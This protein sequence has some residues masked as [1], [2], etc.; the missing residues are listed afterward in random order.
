MPIQL[1]NAG[2]ADNGALNGS[3]IEV[4]MRF[5]NAH[6]RPTLI[7]A[8]ASLL[9]LLAGSTTGRSTSGP[10]GTAP[11]A[12]YVSAKANPVIS[13]WAAN[14]IERTAKNNKVKVWVYFTDRGFAD[15]IG[16]AAAASRQNVTLTTHAA[17]RRAKVG[18]AQVEFSDLPVRQDYV[19][20]IV[21]AGGTLRQ[22]S[23]WL[24][25][26]SFEVDRGLLP[27]ISVLPFVQKIDPVIGFKGVPEP[28]VPPTPPESG[29]LQKPMNQAEPDALNYG[30]SLAQLQQLNIPAVHTLGYKGQGVIVCMMDTGY[31][32][33]HI[34][35]SQ[36]YAGGRVL[37][38]HDFIFNDNNTQN[39]PADIASQHNHGTY[40]WSTL[41]GQ[42]DGSLYGPAYLAQF[43]LAKT[44]DMRSETPVEEDNWV[45][46]ME[47]ADSIGADVISSS[48]GYS[49]WYAY[50]D[51]DGHTAVTSIAASHA[52][53]LGIIVCN[54]AGNNGAGVGTLN[55]PADADSMLAIGAVSSDGSIAAFSSRGPTY[56][57]RMKPEVCALGVSTVCANPGT[58]TT[59]ATAS[60]TSLSCPLAGGCAAV[61][62]SAHPTWTPMQVREALMRTA[63]NT[64]CPNNT[65][66]WGI[67]N[68]LAAVNYPQG[69]KPG[70][71]NYDDAVDIIDITQEISIVFRG[72][73]Y[74]APP[75]SPDITRDCVAN[76]LDIVYLVDYVFRGGPPPPN[77]AP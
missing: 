67:I 54:S 5:F 10:V 74:P 3:K 17:A 32:K 13:D 56:D 48:L 22:K 37:A 71:L 42:A 25:A 66:G 76:V 23:R 19:D 4:C 68:L 61:I 8:A 20:Q 47:W 52:A 38:E 39:E 72:A 49:D 35:F 30:A 6:I 70:D 57:G 60:G 64:A 9:V 51:F 77:P 43:I 65:Y 59:F 12:T 58:T 45:A 69:T 21:A 55:A 16:L 53:A 50:A 40:T 46:G 2:E 41:G 11:Q 62:L 15:D 29:Q 14:V 75:N 63:S 36:A 1:L 18:R 34:A 27:S 26:A 44:E 7:V 33:D 73:A 31:R 24:N 28:E